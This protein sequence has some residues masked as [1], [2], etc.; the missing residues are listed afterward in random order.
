MK[1]PTGWVLVA[2][3]VALGSSCS[4][5]PSGGHSGLNSQQAISVDQF[6][7]ELIHDGWKLT[8]WKFSGPEGGLAADG[9]LAEGKFWQSPPVPVVPLNYLKIE[10]TTRGPGRPFVC[11]FGFNPDAD[12]GR[13]PHELATAGELV[14][15]DWTAW[16]ADQNGGGPIR[17]TYFTRARVNATSGAVRLMGHGVE[18]SDLRV[19]QATPD[20]V[21]EWA[22]GIYQS[23]MAPLEW[24]PDPTIGS[25][26]PNSRALLAAG[27][28]F[29]MVLLG[30]SIMNDTGNSALDVLLE[31][32][33][34]QCEV[35]VITAV[36]GGTG[37]RAWLN[38]SQ[39]RWPKNDL[40][41]N[42]A[43]TRNSP[44]L[45][46]IGGIS[47]GSNWRTDI[48]ALIE[49]IRTSADEASVRQPEILLLT[50][51]FGRSLDPADYAQGLATIAQEANCGFLDLRA[52][53]EAYFENAA[54]A[55]YPR[56]HFFRD[57]LHANHRGK[58][59]LGRVLLR[60]FVGAE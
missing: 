1:I 30:D 40:D 2:C 42:A 47:N 58:Q 52:V 57:S 51:A 6:G 15:D 3:S 14:A 35:D 34:P 26:C 36:G 37:A 17:R 41:L 12:W 21:R 8:D 28:R 55:G 56:E 27:G 23:E 22:D 19:S 54:A 20:E 43:V 39:T 9:T 60:F 11:G 25:I 31:R 24:T 13:F 53:T 10:V 16:E 38:D 59:L 7:E 32:A 45:V 33:F 48:P 44:D 50:G 18:F 46:V 5:E 49:K 29:R 4:K